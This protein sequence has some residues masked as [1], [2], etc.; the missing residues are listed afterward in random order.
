MDGTVSAELNY[1]AW[2]DKQSDERKAQVL[3]QERF[4]LYKAGKLVLEDFYSP[5][6]EWLTL[7][8]IKARDAQA[9]AKMAV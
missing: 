7:D 6:G 8:Q 1:S 3:G 9:F 4:K 2:L 5:S